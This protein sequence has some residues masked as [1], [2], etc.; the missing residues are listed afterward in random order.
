LSSTQ[1]TL[2]PTR[3]LTARETTPSSKPANGRHAISGIRTS[4]PRYG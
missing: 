2:R 3:P 4:C 1:T